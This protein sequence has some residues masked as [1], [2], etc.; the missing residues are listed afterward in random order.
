MAKEDYSLGKIIAFFNKELFLKPV[1]GSEIEFYLLSIDNPNILIESVRKKASDNSLLLKNFTKEKGKNQFEVNFCHSEDIFL[2]AESI[3]SVRKIIESE[4]YK[5]KGEAIFDSCPYQDDYGSAMHIHLSFLDKNEENIL[6]KD[7]D[8][9]SLMMHYVIG[10]LIEMLP[11][12]LLK[13]CP[14]KEDFERFKPNYNAPTTV[15]WGGNNRTVAI[16]LP[17]TTLEPWNRRIEHRVPSAS[18]NPYEV[19]YEVLLGSAYGIFNKIYPG[20]SKIYGDASL[21]Q[22]NLKLI[23]DIVAVV[24]KDNKKLNFERLITK[25]LT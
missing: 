8:E 6:V 14:K 15:S 9:E 20:I 5:L 22:Y 2:L 4:A 13:F 10:G 25:L 21:E 16:R 3:C 19:I 12:S 24:N 17:T 23:K 1:I 18:A 11:F 7:N